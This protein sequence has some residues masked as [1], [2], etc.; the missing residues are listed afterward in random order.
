[1]YFVMR[2]IHVGV[3]GCWLWTGSRCNGGYAQVRRKGRMIMLHRYVHEA[4]VGPISD[5]LDLDHLCRVRHCCN[6][7]H[8]EPVTR[9]ENIARGELRNVIQEL[10][11]ARTECCKGHSYEDAY[12][13]NGKRYCRGCRREAD[14]RRHAKGK[15][16]RS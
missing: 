5:G 9:K 13:Y 10:A 4:M 14:R 3:D 16:A 6:P 11:Q 1:M 7:R 8:L 12:I 2:K 15:L